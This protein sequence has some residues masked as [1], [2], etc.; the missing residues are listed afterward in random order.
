MDLPLVLPAERISQRHQRGGSRGLH[1]Y[2][3]SGSRAAARTVR[4]AP[5]S[6]NRTRGTTHPHGIVVV[7]Q[8][9]VLA[10]QVRQR[11]LQLVQGGSGRRHFVGTLFASRGWPPRTDRQWRQSPPARRPPS[12]KTLLTPA[13]T[14][15]PPSLACRP[16]PRAGQDGQLAAT[17]QRL[18]IMAPCESPSGAA[19]G[20]ISQCWVTSVA[21]PPRP[22]QSCLTNSRAISAGSARTAAP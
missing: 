1:R 15:P 14:Y 17:A 21:V 13:R 4:L 10:A 8:R 18:P 16:R 11:Q 7:A 2:V 5:W 6:P 20:T 22:P 12:I 3:P 19:G 9:R